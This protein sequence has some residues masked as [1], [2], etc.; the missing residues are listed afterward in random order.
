M[1]KKE[2][3]N[4]LFRDDLAAIDPEIQ[5]LI[6][7]EEERQVRKII[8][9]ASESTAPLA[10]RKALG[11]VFTNLYAEGYSS[12]KMCADT[13]KMLLEHNHELS[14]LR[15]YSDRRYYKGVENVD[16]AESLARRRCAE[17]FAA[18]GVAPENVYV[19]VQALSGAAA[20]NAVYQAFLKSGDTVMGL[21]L[22]HGGHL[23]HGSPVNRS[24]MS[25]NVVAYKTSPTTGLLDYDAIAKLAKEYKPKMIIAG[26][27]AYPR[28]IDWAKFR[29]IADGIGNGC[30]VLADISHPAGLVAAGQFPS[31]IG[32]ADVT[33]FT[34]H[35]TLCGPRGACLIT[36]D[37]E[38][39]TLIDAGVFPGEQGGPHINNIAAKAVSF[40]I[41]G[42]DAFRELQ[43]KIVENARALA[44]AF[45]GEGMN[46]AYGGTDSHMMLIDLR[47]FKGLGGVP[48][49]AEVP[50]RILDICGLTC[51]KN[52]IF[53]DEIPAYP[54]GLRFGTTW[55]TQRGLGPDHMKH[56][57]NI[58]SK[59]INNIKPFDYIGLL[60]ILGRGKVQLRVM[61]EA[62]REIAEIASEMKADIEPRTDSGYPYYTPIEVMTGKSTPLGDAHRKTGAKM[63]EVGGRLVAKS[64]S[65]TGKEVEAAKNSAALLD[66]GHWTP[67]EV[68]GDRVRQFV[69]QICTSDIYKMKPGDCLHTFILDDECKLIDDVMVLRRERDKFDRDRFIICSH[70]ENSERLLMWLRGLADG[71]MIFD[72]DDIT[73]K[74]E[75]PAVVKDLTACR[76]VPERR[77]ILAVVGPKSPA[78]LGNAGKVEAGKFIETKIG[79]TEATVAHFP[80]AVAKDVFLVFA[81]PDRVV[82]LWSKLSESGL[83]PAGQA[84]LDEMRKGNNLP[85][86]ETAERPTGVAL[87]EQFKDWFDLYKFYFVGQKE[88]VEAVKPAADKKLFHWEEQEGEDRKTWLYE[89]HLKLTKKAF[90]IPFAGWV[91]PVWYT[92]VGEEHEAVRKTAGLFDVSHMGVLGF[93]GDYAARF[94]DMVTTNYVFWINPGQSQYAYI[95]GPHGDIIDDCMVYCLARDRYMMVVNASNA[96]KVI[97]WFNFV[98]SGEALLDLDN[99]AKRLESEFIFRDLKDP[100]SGADSRIDVALQGPNSLKILQAL[101][102]DPARKDQLAR[103]QRTGLIEINLA[104]FDLVVSRTGY[105]GEEIAFE[106]FVHPDKA[107]EFWRLLLEKGEP[108]GIKPTGLGARDSTRTEAGL[109]LYGHELEGEMGINPMGAGYPAYVKLHK[110]FFVGKKALMEKEKTRTM[111]IVRWKMNQKGVKAVHNGDPVV[112]RRGQFIGKVASACLVGGY[113]LGLAYVGGKYTAEGTPIGIFA[114]PHDGKMKAENAKDHLAKGDKLY[115][116]EWATVISRFPVREVGLPMALQRKR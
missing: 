48:M 75:G 94:L 104:G 1:A 63:G 97:A 56:I 96:E 47:K 105:T 13:E 60:G 42:T 19:N 74:V 43:T 52:A 21:D 45:R 109:P 49:R 34:T 72:H 26:Y 22:A 107:P 58:V 44:E 114:L 116:H 30:V 71:Y 113:Q 99:P 103:I 91:M 87:C 62:K 10:V 69:T 95:L 2:N 39:A 54:S 51:N 35:K 29:E 57:A 16:F 14:Y 6:D 100:S 46:I 28:T 79:D 15:R 8:M 68:V 33:S 81:H 112:N 78:V 111:E 3:A 12:L 41:A 76:D 7:L 25:Y 17:L 37:E 9:I 85:L 88:I 32:I 80:C 59:V 18:N 83:A 4:F 40:R 11:S 36:T 110:P 77:A 93:D 24:G 61:E 101:T 108:F 82:G 55:V 23:T 106:I 64:F 5:R 27:S 31:P 98:I 102:D 89:E 115:L 90:M 73:G 38:K 66:L 50:S 20:N 65:L 70:P 92:S 67:I 86:Y 84:A 53:N